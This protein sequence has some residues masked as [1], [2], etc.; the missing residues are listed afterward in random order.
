MR[1]PEG[2]KLLR[3]RLLHRRRRRHLGLLG[4]TSA[5]LCAAR[6]TRALLHPH[7]TTPLSAPLSAPLTASLTAP[8]TAPLTATLT[9]PLAAPLLHPSPHPSL[10]SSL[11]PSLHP[12]LP[13]ADWSLD[14]APFLR[15]EASPNRA[16]S[17]SMAR[18]RYNA[19][20]GRIRCPSGAKCRCSARH[21]LIIVTIT[22]HFTLFDEFP[23]CTRF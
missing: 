17:P 5:Y 21:T 19:G 22:I 6:P 20:G 18:G 11:H 1:A 23:F 3:Q 15:C 9:A 4:L 13:T 8:L 2:R 16:A 10:H 12:S 7:R 14:I